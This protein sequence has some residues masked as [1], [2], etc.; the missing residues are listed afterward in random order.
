MARK[1]KK[2]LTIEEKLEI[3]KQ[4]GLDNIEEERIHFN[5]PTYEFEIGDRVI[6]GAL[7]ESIV[8]YISDDKKV[9]GLRCIATDNNY[10][11]PYDYQTYRIC[12]WHEIRPIT[13]GTTNFGS[14]Q[15]VRIDFVNSTIESLIHKYYAFGINMNP[16]YQRDYVWELSDKQLL[17]DSIFNNIDI[18]KF[19]FIHLDYK[20]WNKTGYAYE[21]L[22]GKQR[23]KTIIDF[24]ENRLSYKGIYY[25][26]LSKRD[27]RIFNNHHII[28]G[29]VSETERKDVLKY[30]LMLNRTGKVMDQKHLDKVE[31]MY[32][33]L[34]A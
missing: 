17:I 20:T 31:Q 5:E 27:Q 19:A 7:K 12:G 10:G 11:N 8:D 29:E 2:E 9:Y 34:D 21:I 22:D 15:D 16:D 26:D 28:Q 24:Y 33:E 13:H 6:Y 1:S 25:N 23:L 30:F 14:N 3:E 4:R 32:Q 18:G